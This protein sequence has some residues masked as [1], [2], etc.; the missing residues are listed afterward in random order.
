M[1]G[2]KVMKKP[3]T[4]LLCVVA[5]FALFAS[6][7]GSDGVTDVVDGAVDAAGDAA[8]SATD[9]A[10]DAAD[11]VEDAVTGDDEEAMEEESMEEEAMEEE[12]MEEEA[13]EEDSSSDGDDVALS[14]GSDLTFHMITHSDDGPFWSVVKR[15]MEASC[16]NLGVDCV[17]LGSNNDAGVQVQM[18][19]QAI[20]EG[21]EGI[22]VYTLNS[23]VNQYQEIGA[24]THV[25]Q[26]EFIAG[27][28][29]GNRFNDLGA[30]KIL[31]G[32]QEEDNVALDATVWPTPSA[33]RSSASSSVRMPT[34]LS[35][36][37]RS[38]PR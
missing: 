35:S 32:R 24:T 6:G 21:S 28:G 36:R 1:E 26:T 33:V 10:G 12:S 17:W 4:W 38:T 9:A 31:C 16:S 25:G 3:F 2:N 13:M 23:G 11:A 18:I 27:Q 8:D 20:A 19:E 15:G 14:Q 30:T 34:R 5:V 37:R 7:C 29:A 22:P